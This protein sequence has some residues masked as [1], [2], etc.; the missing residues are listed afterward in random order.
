MKHHDCVCAECR[1]PAA[2]PVPMITIP[3]H[4]AP[5]AI[6]D[7]VRAVLKAHCLELIEYGG[8]SGSRALDD[9]RVDEVCREIGRN[10]AQCLV[11]LDETDNEPMPAPVPVRRGVRK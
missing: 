4:A 7:S 10:A 11:A 3:L 6:A 9:Y 1:K 2:A 8:V 5:E